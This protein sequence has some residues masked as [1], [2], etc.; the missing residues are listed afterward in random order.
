MAQL[1]QHEP[2]GRGDVQ[3]LPRHAQCPHQPHRVGLGALTGGEA[4][5]REPENVA[6]RAAFAI[7]RPGR[8]DQSV[9]G[10]QSSRDSDHQLGHPD[11]P[12]PLLEPGDLDV[13]GL[14]TVRLQPRLVRGR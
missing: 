8:D 13:V 6:A 5:Q 12:Q 10:V 2:R 3:L 14:I 7:H 11:R 9:G 1:G 4:R